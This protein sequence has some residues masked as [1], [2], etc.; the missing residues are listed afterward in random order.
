MTSAYR[1]GGVF[2]KLYCKFLYRYLRVYYNC[3]IPY[4]L[5]LDGVYFC[6]NGFG[7]VINPNSKIGKGTVIQNSVCIGE[8]D[9]SHTCPTIGENCFIG[10]H[11]QVLGNITI[12]NNVKIGAGAVVISDIPEG[13]TAV[14]VPAKILRK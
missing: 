2:S 3:D 9:G 4:M 11:A 1:L 10:A 6:H 8:I 5:N 12:G 7:I 13:C 14:G